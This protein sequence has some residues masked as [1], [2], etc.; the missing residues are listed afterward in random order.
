MSEKNVW[1]LEAGKA[2][3]LIRNDSSLMAFR[4]PKCEISEIKGFHI[5]AA[6]TDSPAFKVKESPEMEREGNYVVWNTEKYGGMILSTW[7]DRPLTI[8]GRVC[9]AKENE[10]FSYP[11]KLA[12]NICMIPNLAIHMNR[13]VNNGVALNPQI[14]MLPLY[15]MKQEEGYKSLKEMVA[16]VLSNDLGEQICKEDILGSDLFVENCEKTIL[17]G[18]NKEFIMAPRYDDLGCVYGGLQ[19]ILESASENYINVYAIFDNEEVLIVE[20]KAPSCAIANKEIEQIERYRDRIL[21]SAA[22]PKDKTCYKINL[23]ELSHRFIFLFL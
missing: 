8:A 15:T 6:H 16:D 17:A 2:Y 1:N 19:A 22:Y 9:L 11:V 21:D 3:Y 4:V 13:D 20:L 12:D 10:I 18:V 7:M 23:W 14:D 5:F